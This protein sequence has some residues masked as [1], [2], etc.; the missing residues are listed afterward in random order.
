MHTMTKRQGKSGTIDIKAVLAEDEE[1]LRALV[2]MALQEV[3]EAE[4]TEALGGVFP[5]PVVARRERSASGLAEAPA[6]LMG[7]LLV[8][9]GDPRSKVGLQ[10]VD[11]AAL[12]LRAGKLSCAIT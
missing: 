2:R 6:A 10:L 11:R 8:V 5:L 9:S 7:P 1:F 12:A 3:L 4:M